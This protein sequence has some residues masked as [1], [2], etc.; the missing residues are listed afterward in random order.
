MFN[1]AWD[2]AVTWLII[3][4]AAGFFLCDIYRDFIDRRK[5]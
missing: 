1:P 3:G 2:I 5:K 4:L